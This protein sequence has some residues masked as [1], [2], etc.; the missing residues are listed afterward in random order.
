MSTDVVNEELHTD[1]IWAPV[2][3]IEHSPLIPRAAW[4]TCSLGSLL[5]PASRYFISYSCKR[6]YLVKGPIYALT[7]IFGEHQIIWC[8]LC[9]GILLLDQL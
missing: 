6:L 7:T 8:F 5:E 3:E 1:V 2:L 4:P 9:S